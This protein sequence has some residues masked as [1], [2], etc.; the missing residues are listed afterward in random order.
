MVAFATKISSYY[1]GDAIIYVFAELFRK[2]CTL[3]GKLL[4]FSAIL[5]FRNKARIAGCSRKNAGSQNA[6]FPARLRDG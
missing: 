3:Q 2:K 6:G 5:V 1:I 4:R